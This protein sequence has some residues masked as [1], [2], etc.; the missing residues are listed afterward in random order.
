MK[1][2]FFGDVVGKA[3]RT[4]IKQIL[5]QLKKQYQ[6]DLVLANVENLA[7]GKGLT[8]KTLQEIMEA[9]IDAFTSGN[10]V[11]KKGEVEQLVKECRA[12]L[13]TPANDPRTPAGRGL[14]ELKVG[15]HRL[16]VINMLGRVFM[17]E[18]DLSCPFRDMDKILEQFHN[19]EGPILLDFHAET[20][21]E[22]VALGWYLDGRVS[23]VIGTHTH[24]PTS[25]YR[26]LPQGTA[27]VTDLGM[28]GP[29]DSVLGVKKELIIEKFLTDGPIV[30]D[31][32]SSGEVE[33]NALYLELEDN[34]HRAVRLE[35][36]SQKISI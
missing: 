31:Y 13:V 11:W 19:F 26:I 21:S 20:T 2:L 29:A 5:P 30:F 16:L 34:S 3:G 12:S 24:V 15:T 17:N 6:P 35:K 32:A 7:H 10:H 28:V 18:K 33:I 25:D 36:I 4:A 22:K 8:A 14:M 27:Y 23:A 9:G 1:L